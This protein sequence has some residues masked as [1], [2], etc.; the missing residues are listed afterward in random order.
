A[1]NLLPN[2]SVCGKQFTDRIVG[3]KIADPQEFPWMALI[4]YETKNGKDF[5]CGGTLINSRYVLTAAHCLKENL[6][7]V[8]LGEYDLD[9]EVDCFD[10]ESNDC[11]DKPIDVKVQEKIPHEQFSLEVRSYPHDI[12]LLRLSEDIPYSDSIM[13]ICLPLEEIPNLSDEVNMTVAGWGV[14]ESRTSSPVKLK[15][16]LP[17]VP[18]IECSSVYERKTGVKISERQICAGGIKGVDACIGDSGNPLMFHDKRDDEEN[19]IAIGVVSF[20]IK[21]G[22]ENIPGVYTRVSSYI[23]WIIDH[24]KE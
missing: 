10:E 2:R 20:G 4:E 13:P 24:I 5:Q 6:V 18:N 21:C 14:T 3:G 22:D 23:Q 8:R 7:S 16:E 12:G 9:K 17:V 15:A 11:L 1:V 19:F